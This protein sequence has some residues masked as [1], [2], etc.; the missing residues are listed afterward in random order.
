MKNAMKWVLASAV[1]AST[2]TVAWAGDQIINAQ[3]IQTVTK[4]VS[5]KHAL[6]LKDDDQVKVKGYVVKALGDEEYQFRDATGHIVVE[7]DDELWQ[8]K[9]VSAKT[10]V[11]IVGEID[12]DY[13]PTKKVKIDADEIHF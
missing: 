9:K 12:V 1:I 3:A 5:V 8:G 4:A 7:I 6:G 2:A 11:T 10:P 13:E